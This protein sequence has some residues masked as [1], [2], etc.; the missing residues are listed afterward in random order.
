VVNQNKEDNLTPKERAGSFIQLWARQ[1]HSATIEQKRNI[2]L[3]Y[4]FYILGLE[5]TLIYQFE[6]GLEEAW[7]RVGI[8]QNTS[9]QPTAEELRTFWNK[10]RGIFPDKYTEDDV[11][12]LAEHG[13]FE[14][15][16]GLLSYLN[17]KG[18]VCPILKNIMISAH[19]YK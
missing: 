18:P 16:I 11:T 13:K 17:S 5:W 6:E 12:F 4:L 14:A 15:V 8:I 2:A 19:L 9:E 1:S 3:D 7:S 10:V